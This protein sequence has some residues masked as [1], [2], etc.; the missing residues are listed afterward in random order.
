MY[1]NVGSPHQLLERTLD[2]VLHNVHDILHQGEVLH[3]IKEPSLSSG[4]GGG[5]AFGYDKVPYSI[6]KVPEK[7]SSS[8]VHKEK[9]TLST[10][11][12]GSVEGMK[13]GPDV[14][15]VELLRGQ[16]QALVDQ[17][18]QDLDGRGAVLKQKGIKKAS[19]KKI[20]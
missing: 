2:A 12:V 11:S 20:N 4:E 13:L 7:L 5:D 9:Q 18:I 14:L 1:F 3:N 15:E 16:D 6:V 19:P 10:K 8:G 17:L